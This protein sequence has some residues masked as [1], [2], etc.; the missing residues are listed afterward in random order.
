M[1]SFP[2]V[3]LHWFVSQWVGWGVGDRKGMVRIFFL[4]AL[5]EV[6][7]SRKLIDSSMETIWWLLINR[8][9]RVHMIDGT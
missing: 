9:Q 3:S 8:D 4:V 1:H 5:F 2:V 7:R 6:H